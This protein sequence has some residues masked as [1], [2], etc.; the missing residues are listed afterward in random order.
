MVKVIDLINRIK[1]DVVEA[2][3]SREIQFNKSLIKFIRL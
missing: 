2:I 3:K 1:D